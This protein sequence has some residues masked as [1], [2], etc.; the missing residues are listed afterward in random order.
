[1]D[2]RQLA[3]A[4]LDWGDKQREL[5]DLET[6]ITA[7]V[8]QLGKTQKVGD[9]R[10]TYSAGKKQYDYQIAAVDP[11][12][13]VVWKHSKTVVDWKSV[14]EEIGATSIPCKQSD[15]SVRVKLEVT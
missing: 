15:P 3:Q 14:C 12:Q 9:V 8:L 10:A 6:T 13:E 1:M 5:N 7:A 11:P 2:A 4:L